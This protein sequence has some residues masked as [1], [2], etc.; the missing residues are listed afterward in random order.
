MILVRRWV[1][2]LLSKFACRITR[3]LACGS[4]NVRICGSGASKYAERGLANLPL[5][6]PF[7]EDGLALVAEDLLHRRMRKS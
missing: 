5:S 6:P 1:L 3:Q 7:K 2:G 4:V